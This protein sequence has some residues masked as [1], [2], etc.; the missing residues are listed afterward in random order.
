MDVKRS[1]KALALVVAAL[2]V[3]LMPA[4]ARAH[5]GAIIPSTE[6]VTV[7]GDHSV[8]LVFQFFHPFEQEWMDLERPLKAGYW[9][10]GRDHSLLGELRPVKL[11]GHGAWRAT[12][13]LRQPGDYIFYMVPKPYWEPAEG[14]YIQHCTKV[15]VN[16]FGLE[17]GWDRPVGLPAEIVPEVRPY[18]LWAGNLFCGRALVHG[19]PAPGL[20]VEVEYLNRAGIKAPAPPFTTQVLKTDREGRFC[21][22]MPRAGWWGFAALSD[23]EGAMVHQGRRVGLELGAVIWVRTREMR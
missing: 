12:V 5:F 16:G 21:Y 11:H 20:R 19:R 14:I 13:L 22:A 1:V 6:V 9:V 23:Q 8:G 7:A 18:G 4:T 2:A 3:A 10:G 15:V 17:N